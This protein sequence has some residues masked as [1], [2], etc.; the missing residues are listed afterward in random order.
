M[1]LRVGGYYLLFFCYSRK[2]L[3]TNTDCIF[4]AKWRDSAPIVTA[5]STDSPPTLTTVMLKI[6]I[7]GEKP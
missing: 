4:I 3:I 2:T 6:K 7:W 5:F 1:K